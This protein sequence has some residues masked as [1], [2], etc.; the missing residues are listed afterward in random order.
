MSNV[1]TERDQKWTAED[2][3]PYVRS[4]LDL[5][6]RGEL[7]IT[8]GLGESDPI[9]SPDEDVPKKSVKGHSYNKLL[10][11]IARNIAEDKSLEKKA[12]KSMA[13]QLRSFS[14]E[15][16]GMIKLHT[17]PA[18]VETRN[19]DTPADAPAET[20]VDFG[21]VDETAKHSM[22][23]V[24][25]EVQSEFDFEA[26]ELTPAQLKMKEEFEKKKQEVLDTLPAEV[27]ARFGQQYFTKWGKNLLP[28]LVMSPYSIPP[29][30]ARDEWFR[31]YEKVSGRITIS[32]RSVRWQSQPKNFRAGEK[33]R[34]NIRSY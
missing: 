25:S 14:E 1:E 22:G 26:M 7:F 19:T 23:E 8:T 30:P 4:A 6:K 9:L 2:F 31:M 20:P 11:E 13:K 32:H 21:S 33:T 10:D 15:W 28:C 24:E 34:S 18:N 17:T 5:W 3:R 29:G 12:K 27:K 16:A